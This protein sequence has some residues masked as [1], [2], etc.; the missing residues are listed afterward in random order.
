MNKIY[1]GLFCDI[2]VVLQRL[3][4]SKAC[5]DAGLLDRCLMRRTLQF[6]TTVAEFLLCIM[7]EQ[8][9]TS[10]VPSPHVLPTC[11]EI[12]QLFAALPEWYLEDIADFLLFALQ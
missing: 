5:A 3:T 2:D 7:N 6:Y 9:P 4:R 10:A 1:T 8:T 12:P 11:L